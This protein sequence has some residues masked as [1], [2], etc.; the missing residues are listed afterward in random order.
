MKRIG[1][2]Y[3]KI[4]DLENLRSAHRNARKKKGHYKDVKMVNSNED[5]YLKQ[6]QEMFINKTYKTSQYKIF[7]KWDRV[8]EREIYKLP[9]FPDRIVQWAI[10]QVIEPYLLKT[11]VPNTLSSIKKRGIHQG[12]NKVKYALKYDVINTKYCLKL[13]IR[14]YYPS[15]NHEIL[16]QKYRRIST[17][18]Q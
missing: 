5:Y 15:I 10:M 17:V 12:L 3:K 9:Y 11:L 6:I 13:D 8:K 4:Y 2:L 14:H 16:K 18:H 1:N 7:K